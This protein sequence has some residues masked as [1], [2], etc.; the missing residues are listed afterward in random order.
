MK[1]ARFLSYMALMVVSCFANAGETKN[2][3]TLEASNGF[4]FWIFCESQESDVNTLG[5][6]IGHPPVS[7]LGIGIGDPPMSEITLLEPNPNPIPLGPGTGDPPGV[8]P[9]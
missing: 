4:C 1:L 3:T 6:G 7:T 2:E 9:N 8:D 5:I